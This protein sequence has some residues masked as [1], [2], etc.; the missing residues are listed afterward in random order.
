MA[1]PGPAPETF[2]ERHASVR[3]SIMNITPLSEFIPCRLI[4][5]PW[6]RP[7]FFCFRDMWVE[8]QDLW[9]IEPHVEQFKEAVLNEAKRREL[10][11]AA[12]H[13]TMELNLIECGP[14]N[15]GEEQILEHMIVSEKLERH[16]FIIDIRI[17]GAISQSHVCEP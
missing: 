9:V 16:N 2:S 6:T 3:Q 17:G 13:A 11:M 1:G 12:V 14:C 10:F 4:R 7:C 15:R 5:E 8:E